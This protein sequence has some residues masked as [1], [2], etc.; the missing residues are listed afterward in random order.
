[1]KSKRKRKKEG[2]S[3]ASTGITSYSEERITFEEYVATPL[4][5]FHFLFWL[6][7][8]ASC[9]YIFTISYSKLIRLVLGGS[10]IFLLLFF[11]MSYFR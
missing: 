8:I 3:S 11:A 7:I 2:S 5:L 10:Y 4:P 6:F 1:M 9:W